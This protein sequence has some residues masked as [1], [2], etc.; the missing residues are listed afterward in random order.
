MS[1]NIICEK[2]TYERVRKSDFRVTGY[3]KTSTRMPGCIAHNS[4][5]NRSFHR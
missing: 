5:G 2:S 3:E 1:F 4:T